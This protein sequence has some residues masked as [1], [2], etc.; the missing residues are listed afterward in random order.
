MKFQ[1]DNLYLYEFMMED[2]ENEA[3]NLPLLKLENEYNEIQNDILN[4]QKQITT[5][6]NLLSKI[7]R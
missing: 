6:S 1:N 2:K 5:Y 3:K 7:G 4:T